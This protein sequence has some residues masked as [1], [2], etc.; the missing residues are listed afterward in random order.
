MCVLHL[1]TA[2][3]VFGIVFTIW[4]YDPTNFALELL[5]TEVSEK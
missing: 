1:A 2:T 4:L 3:I 5:P